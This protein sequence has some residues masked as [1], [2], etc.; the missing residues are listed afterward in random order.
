MSTTPAQ[1]LETLLVVTPLAD[2]LLEQLRSLFPEVLYYP[3]TEFP[4]RDP[5]LP[6]LPHP[7]DD[8]YAR[9]DA[10]F[11]QCPPSNLTRWEQTPRLKLFQGVSAGYSHITD[12]D[13][14]A[15]I[16]EDAD[17]SFAS[18]S[19]I[20]VSTIG[21]HV[22]G[23]VLMLT[24]KLHF[25]NWTLRSEQRWVSHSELGGG[26]VRELSSLTVGILGYGH[27]GRETARLFQSCGARILALTR[28]GKP[29]PEKGFA[30]PNTGDPSG[31]LPSQYF[32]T[33][34]RDSIL[35]FLSQCDVVV[36]TLP[37]SKATRGF[38]GEE[39]LKAMKG[40]AIYVNIGRG[41][42]TNQD[43]LIEAL[44]AKS[45]KGER[46]NATGTLRIGAASLDV[47]DPEPL[48][49]G[50]VLYTLPNVVLTP[51]MS[52]LSLSY[53]EKCIAVL[54]QNVKRMRGGKPAFNVYLGKGE[55]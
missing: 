43:K 16:P 48:P 27:I 4:P 20:H 28:A 37:D 24:H 52:G 5:S 14:A 55:P 35:E 29:A 32:T 10:I 30:L 54:E 9:V 15:S 12:T 33:T 8:V 11:G 36:N 25:L 17:V 47:V 50:H 13:F 18:A 3:V 31:T 22:L 42:T 7:S 34:S 1:P 2:N 39:E 45:T 49:Q 41:T 38:I 53:Y 21:E 19:G 40:D 44:Q 26:F 46:A 6:P 51:H 23:T